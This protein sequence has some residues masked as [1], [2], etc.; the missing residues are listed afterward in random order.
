MSTPITCIRPTAVSN[1]ST[2]AVASADQQGGVEEEG[3]TQGEEMRDAAIGIGG[4]DEGRKGVR[5]RRVIL[6]FNCFP[7][8]PGD[9]LDECCRRAPEHSG[10]Y[11]LLEYPTIYRNI[12]LFIGIF[13]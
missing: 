6:G 1:Q 9:A 11:Y 10:D 13:L 7:G 3:M 12:L 2:V 5:M 4:D 8:Q